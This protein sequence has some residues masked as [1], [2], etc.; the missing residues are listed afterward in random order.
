MDNNI[1]IK[2]LSS[3][4]F[5]KYTLTIDGRLYK[6]I[7]KPREMKKDTYNRF[8]MVSDCGK[9][10]RIPLKEIY[11]K[12][13]NKEY[14]IDNINNLTGEEWKPIQ[15]TNGKYYISNCG[16]V[17]S[18][19]KYNAI[20]LQPYQKHNGYLIVKINGKN[21]MIHRLVA[22]AFCDNKYTGQKVEIHHKDFIRSN[23]NANNLII[24]SINEHHKIHKAKETTV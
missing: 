21:I 3:F 8:Y 17:K 4:G 18:L 11:R 22:F 2:N 1:T 10:K 6:G 16:R 5:S 24:L 13:Y 12:A 9:A 15:G 20:I 7:T 14:C 23:N 19:C